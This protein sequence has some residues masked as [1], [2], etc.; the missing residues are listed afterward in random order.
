LSLFLPLSFKNPLNQ[1]KP[2]VVRAFA[3]VQRHL[4]EIPF[5]FQAGYQEVIKGIQTARGALDFGG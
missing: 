4:D 5:V 3:L 2:K 1:L